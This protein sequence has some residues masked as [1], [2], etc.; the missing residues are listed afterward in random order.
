MRKRFS[1]ILGVPLYTPSVIMEEAKTTLEL[2]QAFSWHRSTKRHRR[3]TWRACS[4]NDCRF[5]PFAP[6]RTTGEEPSLR[7]YS[8]FLSADVTISLILG[9][10][11][12]CG[13]WM[14]FGESKFVVNTNLINVGSDRK[15]AFEANKTWKCCASVSSDQLFFC[16]LYETFFKS[17]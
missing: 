14:T 5:Q 3:L 6:D 2:W 7:N 4:N 17:T 13:R 16:L 11:K 8:P 15:V 1:N 12:I 10:E 9:R